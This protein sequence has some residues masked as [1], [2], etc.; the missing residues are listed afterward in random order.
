MKAKFPEIDNQPRD[1]FDSAIANDEVKNI[2]DATLDSIS[3]IEKIKLIK[4]AGSIRANLQTVQSG[5]EKL[6]IMEW[7]PT[8]QNGIKVPK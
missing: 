6:K 7:T 5:M 8:T 3:G 2:G 1:E 4:E